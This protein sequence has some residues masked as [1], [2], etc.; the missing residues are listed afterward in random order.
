MPQIVLVDRED[1]IATS[2]S[3]DVGL[4]LF[5]ADVNALLANG[6]RAAYFPDR[7]AFVPICRHGTMFSRR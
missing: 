6:E 4:V 7:C 5:E 1:R 2:H 3:G